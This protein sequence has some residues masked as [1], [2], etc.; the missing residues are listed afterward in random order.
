[1]VYAGFYTTSSVPEYEGECVKVVF[2]LPKGNVVVILRPVLNPDGSFSLI[3]DGNKIGGPSY[4]RTHYLSP[5]KI[6]VRRIPMHEHIHLFV[7]SEGVLRTDH[8]FKFWGIKFLLLH[9]KIMEKK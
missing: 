3:S 5:G 2:P 4:Y 8:S 7:D 6:K 1:I 9:Y